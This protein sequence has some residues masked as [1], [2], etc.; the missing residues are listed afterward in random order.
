[1]RKVIMI[2][3]LTLV[4]SMLGACGDTENSTS[5]D[6]KQSENVKS[7]GKLKEEDYEKLYSDPE[8]YK[9]YEI[10]ITGRVF[11]EPEKDEDGTYIQFWAD[12]ESSEK[13]TLAAINDPNLNIYTNDYVKVIGMVM[14]EFEGENAFGGIVR[15][16]I[17]LA[18]SIEVVD[19]ITV[20]APTIKEI[21]VNKEINQHDLVITLQKIEIAENQTRVYLK[22]NN[23]TQNKVSFYSHSS[24]LIVGNKQLEEEYFHSETTG[25]QE[26]QS[27]ILPSIET[28]GVIVYPAIDLNEKLIKMHAEAYSDNYDIDFEP[29]V[30]EVSID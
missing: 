17:I 3:C 13:N 23:N 15:A 22:V 24:K 5:D 4:M 27:E 6:N 11:T 25:L 19:Y 20:V 8:K 10:E 1:M 9:G 14:D 26:I 16:P 30:F 28:E 7:K 21:N 18:E 2:A 29:F 12:P